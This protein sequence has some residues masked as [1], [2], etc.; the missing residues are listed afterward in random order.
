MRKLKHS[1]FHVEFA[2]ELGVHPYYALDI[3]EIQICLEPCLDGYCVG[4][5]KKHEKLKRYELLDKK[6]KA[7]HIN[8]VVAK[9]LAIEGANKLWNKYK[10][11]A[12][13]DV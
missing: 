3:G 12:G 4:I 11:K 1:D 13:I 10:N 2:D 6:I 8:H 5:Y 9:G 7:H